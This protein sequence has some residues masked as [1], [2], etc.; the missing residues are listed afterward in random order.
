M[1]KK[2]T[3]RKFQKYLKDCVQKKKKINEEQFQK[4]KERFKKVLKTTIK[5]VVRAKEDSTTRK[6]MFTERKRNNNNRRTT[7]YF[8]NPD[9]I[10]SVK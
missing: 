2:K 1:N 10:R 8:Q 9:R 5:I 3:Y 4:T 7:E 6:K